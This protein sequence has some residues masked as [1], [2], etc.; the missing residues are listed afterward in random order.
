M[1]RFDGMGPRSLG[2]LTGR[3]EGV[4][5]TDEKLLKELKKKGIFFGVPGSG[6]G[7]RGRLGLGRRFN[8]R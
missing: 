4:C 1:P 3:G 2:P 8:R 7:G 6:L 5:V